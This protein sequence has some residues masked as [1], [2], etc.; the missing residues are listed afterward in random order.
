[1]KP[2]NPIVDDHMNSPPRFL[3]VNF[4]QCHECFSCSTETGFEIYNNHPIQ[5]SVKRKFSKNGVS[6]TS[7][8]GYTR[9][10]YRT[11]YIALLGGGMYPRHSTNKIVIWDDIQQKDSISIK[12]NSP[13]K[14]IFLSRQHIVVALSQSIE[15]YTF[16]GSPKR[17]TPRIDHVN[18]GIADF[19]TCNQTKR[20]GS[21]GGDEESRCKNTLTGILAYASSV[22]PGQIHLANL[23]NLQVTNTADDSST[24]L[25]TSIIKAHKSPVHLIR[26]NQKG[27]MVATCSIKGTLIRIFSITS[28]SLVHELR[29]GTDRAVVFDMQWNMNGTELALVSDKY[30]LHVFRIDEQLGKRH[31]LKGLFPRVKYLQGMWSFCSIKVDKS[32]LKRKNDVC[33]IGWISDYTLSLIWR[34]SGIWEQY[35]LTEEKRGVDRSEHPVHSTSSPSEET[36]IMHLVRKSWKQ[37]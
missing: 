1:M 37:L 23:A 11:N 14:E 33:K 34:K 31:A 35:S 32:V 25:P 18:D 28:G 10:L 12:F 15:L 22:S 19:V 2:R 26:F 6:G 36:T 13:V 29:R 17:I 3:H 24:H 30:T 4:N 9:M 20:R 16:S 7:G 27:S 5:C 21:G 8:I